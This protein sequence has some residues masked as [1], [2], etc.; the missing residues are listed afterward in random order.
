MELPPNEERLILIPAVPSSGTS[1]LAGVLH[2]LGVDM[3]NVNNKKPFTMRGYDMYEDD[4]ISKY[5]F[6]PNREPDVFIGKLTA[7]VLRF[8]PYI[9]YR[10][11]N[12]KGPVGAKIPAVLCM[13]DP[14]PATLP[15]VTLNVHRPFEQA[16]ASDRRTML[17]QGRYEPIKDDIDRIIATNRMRASDMGTCFA[18]KMDLFIY[19]EPVA[20]MTFDELVKDKE[21]MVPKIA[22][23]LGLEP[24]EQQL[25]T[26]INFLDKDKKH[27]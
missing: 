11:Y 10:L 16:I 18:A 20:N 1:A 25:Q 4:D 23:S 9:N 27:S 17:K 14:D 22:E 6:R 5:C 3:G 26:A 21:E 2:H 12:A 15:I 13:Y 8:R 7:T 19:H 24:T